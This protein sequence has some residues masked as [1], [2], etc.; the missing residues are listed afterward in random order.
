MQSELEGDMSQQIL[1]VQGGGDGAHAEDQALADYLTRSL[2]E[3]I[4]ILYPTFSGLEAIDYPSW[5]SQAIDTLKDL[6]NNAFIVA[7]SLGGA[8]VLK[9]LSE[10]RPIPSIRA[11]YLLAMP[12][13]CTDGEW[14]SDDFAIANEFAKT[15]PD[16]QQ[17][18]LFHSDDDEWVPFEHLS[19]YA[20][21][22]PAATAVPLA[23]RGHSMMKQ[24]FTELLEAI[25]M[26]LG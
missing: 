2:G 18:M 3:Q 23:N 10:E 8:A 17:M 4:E 16:I 15:L 20:E 5:R 6:G 7:H 14:G 13:K 19:R 1:V 26:H 11:M 21:K 24:D 22:L 25:Q 12:Y 9:V